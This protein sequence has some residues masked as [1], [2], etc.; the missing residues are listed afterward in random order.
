[1]DA[2]KLK[3]YSK[4]IGTLK[5]KDLIVDDYQRQLRVSN[6]TKIVKNYNPVGFGLLQVSHRDGRY[7]VFDGQHRLEAAK[8]LKM[9]TVECLVYE[10]MSYEDEANAWKYFN[11]ASTKPT[12]LDRA[13]VEL[14]TG[15]PLAV[16]LDKCVSRAGFYIDYENQG[17]NGGIAAYL[18]LKKVFIENGEMNLIH[19]LSILRGAFDFERKAFQEST[20]YGVSNFLVEYSS[21]EKYNEKWLIKKLEETGVDQLINMINKSKKM[22]NTTKKEAATSILLQIYNKAKVKDNRLS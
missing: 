14:I 17:A 19:T 18:T 7:F 5:V 11:S 2:N 20:I 4:R 16:E 10:G 22:F 1:M 6:V 13:K 3:K 21:N 9:A 12:Q 15:D 8:R